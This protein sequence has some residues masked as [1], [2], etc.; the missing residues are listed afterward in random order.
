[1]IPER[2]QS[3]LTS[4]VL[5]P[6]ADNLQPWKFCLKGDEV[7]L[8]LDPLRLS[9][10][11]DEGLL[12][13]FVSAG[14]VIENIRV[15]SQ[16][17]GFNPRV[18]Y[19]PDPHQIHWIA[20]LYFESRHATFHAHYE[21]LQRRRTNRKFY[22]SNQPLAEPIFDKLKLAA[23]SEGGT[24]LIWIK[25][26]D[27]DFRGLA[28][29]MAEADELRFQIK[30]LHSELFHMMRFNAAEA[31][32]THD[33]L[34]IRSLELDLPSRAAFKLMR[35]WSIQEFLNQIG[36]TRLF[37]FYTQK[38]I[39]S[40]QAIGL[41]ISE[42][43]Q[44]VDYVHGGEKMERFWH[45]ATL[46]GLSLQPMEALPIFLLNEQQNRLSGFDDLQRKKI[47]EFH[48][49]FYEFFPLKNQQG[50]IFM[51]RLGYAD[52]VETFSLRR[53]LESFMI[54]AGQEAKSIL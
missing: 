15:A 22:K 33:G 20:T 31:L 51:F 41:L 11:C 24:R 8:F 45:E 37:R 10:F 23:E 16:Q 30:R 14:A 19:F 36:F 34:D 50:L 26:K 6:S 4:A 49:R 44:P 52:S 21:V 5:A 1:M 12:K 42:N 9:N 13:P 40:S 17:A 25:K 27:S 39:E 54:P 53:P 18:V 43:N 3:I 35:H 28:K 32:R 7:Q 48:Q 46:Q 47:A 29:L 2:I 38:Q